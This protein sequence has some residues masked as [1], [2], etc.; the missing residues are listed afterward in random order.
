[1][2][3][4]TPCQTGRDALEKLRG[5]AQSFDI[6][7]LRRA[8]GILKV[9]PDHGSKHPRTEVVLSVF[10]PDPRMILRR[11]ESPGGDV[12]SLQEAPWLMSFYVLDRR[13]K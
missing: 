7:W 5:L 9:S 3:E 10:A 4:G 8:R 11:S 12:S 2:T 1:M 13:P 6:A